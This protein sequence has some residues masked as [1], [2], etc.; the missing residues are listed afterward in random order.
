MGRNILLRLSFI[1]CDLGSGRDSREIEHGQDERD[2]DGA[3][4]ESHEDEDNGLHDAGEHVDL[5]FV[6]VVKV[7]GEGSHDASDLGVVFAGVNDL[8]EAGRN[9][10]AF[11]EDFVHGAAIQDTFVH[12]L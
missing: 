7:V 11:Q 5:C 9:E 2:G 6:V 1:C 12:G 4:D 10:R 8:G 3:E